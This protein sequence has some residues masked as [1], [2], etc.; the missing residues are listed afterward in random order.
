MNNSKD[1]KCL[2]D[3]C[4]NNC[5]QGE[6]KLSMI[7][8]V[9]LNESF[10]L[11]FNDSAY[12]FSKGSIRMYVDSVTNI[13]YGLFKNKADGTCPLLSNGLCT[14]YDKVINLSLF[15]SL[16]LSLNA[17]PMI[18]RAYPF[19]IFG[20]GEPSIHLNSGCK[21]VHGQRWS[22]VSKSSIDPLV[23]REFQ[24]YNALTKLVSKESTNDLI[25]MM[26]NGAFID[27]VKDKLKS[28]NQS[29]LEPVDFKIH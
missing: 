5:C 18:C 29:L 16:G 20:M 6:L 22:Y 28:I 11:S 24:F 23:V 9:R 7:D 21:G 10:K 27:Y 12:H 15:K 3:Q 25:L 13:P 8:L 1:F 2:C 19:I 14:I 4:P 26:V 17:K